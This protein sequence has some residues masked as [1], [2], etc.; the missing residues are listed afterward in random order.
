M[1]ARPKVLFFDVN[2]T[3]L[4]LTAMKESVALSLGGR[5]D[6]LPLWFTTLLHYSL[7]ETTAGQYHNFDVI[8]AAALR[9]IGRNYGILLSEGEARAAILPMRT[10]PPH[11]DVAPALAALRDASFRMV[12][13][14]NSSHAMV[15][16]QI[17]HAGLSEFFEDLLSVE[18]VRQFKTQTEVYRWAVG[19]MGLNA[20]DCM[21]IAA[22]GWDVAG[23]LWAG[24]RATFVARQSAQ[25]YPLAPEPE[26]VEPDLIRVANKLIE[27]PKPDSE[28]EPDIG[29]P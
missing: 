8:G 19:K 13:L 22:H 23:A 11:P 4:D 7:V 16:S 9:M 29:T 10:L 15:K 5:D 18:S 21:L 1:N 26:I 14:T 27:L 24:C 20:E 12:P 3:L 2:E 28:R 25:L 6:L 17:G